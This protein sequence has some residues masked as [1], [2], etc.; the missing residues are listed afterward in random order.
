MKKILILVLLVT[1]L[2]APVHAQE[3]SQTYTPEEL[4]QMWE[5][6]ITMMREAECYPYVDLRQGDKGYEV[7]FLQTRLAQL[8]YYGK[9]IDPQFGRGTYSAMRMF[10]KVHNLPVN[11]I[12]SVNDQKLLFSSKA[13]MNSG[14]PAGLEAGQTPPAN[15][16]NQLFPGWLDMLATQSP[17]P[18]YDIPFIIPTPSPSP[19]P[20]K[21]IPP[22]DIL[23][24][25]FPFKTNN[26]F[27]IITLKP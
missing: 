13:K 18:K 21:F 6:I 24:T 27:P 17:K 3:N 7:I 14:T 22:I 10:E 25:P 15:G 12:A 16:G 8:L 9:A 4:L 5:Q 26:N 1:L 11:G 2:L 23:T 19:Q 20:T